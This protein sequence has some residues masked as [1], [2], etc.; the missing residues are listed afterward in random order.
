MES[1]KKIKLNDFEK[2]IQELT[3]SILP[4]GG[5]H[6]ARKP[7]DNQRFEKLHR[8]LRYKCNINGSRYDE[9]FHKLIRQKLVDFLSDERKRARKNETTK[10]PPS[11]LCD[12]D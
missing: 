7:L 2:E 12:Q 9:F 11:S 5:E 10:S 8:V 6:F 4:P 3:S 1:T